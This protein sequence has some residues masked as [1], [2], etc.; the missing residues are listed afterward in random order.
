M[1]PYV[2]LLRACDIIFCL[3][4][5]MNNGMQSISSQCIPTFAND[6]DLRPL[7]SKI[8]KIHPLIMVNVSARFDEDAHKFSF[9][10]V[11]MV[12]L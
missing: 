5:M 4:D 1:I 3:Y 6:L 12:K 10:R 7:T 9:Y 8:N 11:H 2:A